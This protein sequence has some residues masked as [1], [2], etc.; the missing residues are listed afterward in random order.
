MSGAALLLAGVTQADS[1]V[2]LGCDLIR[3]VSGDRETLMTCQKFVEDNYID[4]RVGTLCMHYA[5]T[6]GYLDCLRSGARRDYTAEDFIA[7]RNGAEASVES[8]EGCLRAKGQPSKKPNF[9]TELAK[10]VSWLTALRACRN[11]LQSIE[12][13]AAS[14]NDGA[15]K[16][17]L[18]DVRATLDT[19][20]IE[21]APAF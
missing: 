11:Q 5:P 9:K 17:L 16:R 20:E 18:P 21:S 19:L 14:T 8:L 1:T 15:L 7:C 3:P 4:A 12:T 13:R 6:A 10:N 2:L